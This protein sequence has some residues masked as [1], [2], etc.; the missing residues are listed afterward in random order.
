ML[1][2]LQILPELYK[3][4]GAKN[5]TDFARKVDEENSLVHQWLK[6]N[7]AEPRM[8]TLERVCGKLGY[9]LEIRLVKDDRN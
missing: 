8:S 7:P 9:K 3:I 5:H 1:K 6:V 2:V 4:S